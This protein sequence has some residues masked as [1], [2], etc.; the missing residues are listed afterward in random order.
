[1]QWTYISPDDYN[2][3]G[4]QWKERILKNWGQGWRVIVL[5]NKVQ[6]TKKNIYPKSVFMK[7]ILII[8]FFLKLKKILKSRNKIKNSNPV[9]L[10]NPT[11]AQRGHLICLHFSCID[12]IILYPVPRRMLKVR[13]CNSHDW[14]SSYQNNFY[15]WGQFDNK[16]STEMLHYNKHISL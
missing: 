5:N 7:S 16:L 8:F 9:N 11:T 15:L 14:K 1:M 12:V 10:A 6:I 3:K 2:I 4:N 13:K